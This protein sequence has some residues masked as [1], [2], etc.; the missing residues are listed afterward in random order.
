MVEPTCDRCGTLTEPIRV[1]R[2]SVEYAGYGDELLC[3]AC[4]TEWK[5]LKERTNREYA[6]DNGD[7]I[8]YSNWYN[9]QYRK[10]H[11][12][13]V[14]ERGRSFLMAHP[15]YAA[16]TEHQCNYSWRLFAQENDSWVFCNKCPKEL[17]RKRLD[18]YYVHKFKNLS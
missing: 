13:F 14:K 16:R 10:N 9:E 15:G 18:D 17:S 12:I 3:P 2:T 1:N 11:E 7:P 8:L 4:M 5:K 6:E